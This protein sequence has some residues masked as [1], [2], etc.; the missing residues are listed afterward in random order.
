L[1]IKIFGKSKMGWGVDAEKSGKKW[2]R[3]EVGEFFLDIFGE[4]LF[5]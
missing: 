3:S 5:K 4:N 2:G 1:H